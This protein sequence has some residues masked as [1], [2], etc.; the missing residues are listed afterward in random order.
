VRVEGRSREL[1]VKKV[2]SVRFHRSLLTA[3][4]DGYSEMPGICN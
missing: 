3:G 1:R 4:L 2:S